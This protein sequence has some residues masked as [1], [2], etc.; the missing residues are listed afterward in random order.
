MFSVYF[1]SKQTANS[2][3]VWHSVYLIIYTKKMLCT[4]PFFSLAYY[5]FCYPRPIFGKHNIVEDTL[6]DD[7]IRFHL[8]TTD[9]LS[10]PRCRPP[11]GKVMP[12][13]EV[14]CC[15]LNTFFL[16]AWLQLF[17]SHSKKKRKCFEK[18]YRN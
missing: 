9:G 7:P 3:P 17:M 11:H 14:F 16:F 6:L 4:Q 1:S 18:K 10:L 8:L 15:L 12:G 2:K 13:S 5:S